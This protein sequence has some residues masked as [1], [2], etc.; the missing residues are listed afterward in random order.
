MTG[1]VRAIA[2]DPALRLVAALVVLFGSFAAT[3]VPYF[4]LIA[5]QVF[6]LGDRGYAAVAVAASLVAVSFAIGTG[7]VADQRANRRRIA[8]FCGVVNVAGSGLMVAAP[9]APMLI[10]AHALILPTGSAM[11]GQLF[12]L[13][14]LAA[15]TAPPDARDGIL[16]TVRA[17]F[18][19]PWVIALPVLSAAVR[20][21][22]P[23]T[24]VYA[25]M[26]AL[27]L[28]MLGLILRYWP[29]DGG[30]RWQDR[31]S[32]LRLRAALR[33][34]AE[35][36][37]ALRVG[38]TGIVASGSTINIALVGLIFTTVG[39]RG[40]A[41]VALFIGLY[42]GLEV[43]FM[44]ATPW[45]LRRLRPGTLIALGA[46]V[47]ALHLTLL[48]PL[49]PTPFVWLLVIPAAAGGAIYLSVLIGYLQDLMADRPGA[50]SSLMAVQKI[51]GDVVSA[52]AF[53]IGTALSGY[54]LAA[55]LAAAAAVTAG[56]TLWR[57]DR[58]APAAQRQSKN[59]A[60]A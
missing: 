44:L 47:F 35:P 22:L 56:A 41:D 55:L 50:G 26:L 51:A 54:G 43:P 23:V 15:S 42:A 13:A 34:M 21:G 25:V 19:L 59:P 1:P 49:S 57:I 5:V 52:A 24:S 8:I 37:V 29:R 33:E 11:F 6:G 58:R 38:L 39:H 7:I 31:P 45:M 2:A 28:V 9:S 18:A 12:A 4:S 16:A 46:A 32:G 48:A 53:L 3:A 10:L 30:T 14:R 20:A 17:A 36:R 40:A 60:G 27:A